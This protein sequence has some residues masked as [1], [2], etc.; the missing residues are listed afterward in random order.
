M[1]DT[2]GAVESGSLTPTFTPKSVHLTHP[3]YPGRTRNG[4]KCQLSGVSVVARAFHKLRTLHP[5]LANCDD[6][7][8]RLV[9][10][11]A[12]RNQR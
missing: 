2:P 3:L 12:H 4:P 6:R 9:S 5:R 1:P 7:G 8:I 11:G 10:G